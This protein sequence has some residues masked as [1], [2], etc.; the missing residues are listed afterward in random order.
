MMLLQNSNRGVR[1]KGSTGGSGSPGRRLG[2]SAALLYLYSHSLSPCIRS[3]LPPPLP[4]GPTCTHLSLLT[5]MERRPQLLL[6][7]MCAQR[8]ATPHTFSSDLCTL[9]TYSSYS[10]FL[11]PSFPLP[12]FP[13]P[14]FPPSSLYCYSSTSTHLSLPLHP[15]ISPSFYIHPSLPP[16]TSTHLS[17]PLPRPILPSSPPS[18][19]PTLHPRLS[20]GVFQCY[21]LV[22]VHLRD[23]QTATREG[24]W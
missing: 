15:P 23:T 5:F 3:L 17:L 1:S 24:D 20:K 19:P 14:T 4:W 21:W 22:P 8:Q 10:F 7:Q 13:L 16:S 18:F 12:T 6:V 2:T 9:L 11:S